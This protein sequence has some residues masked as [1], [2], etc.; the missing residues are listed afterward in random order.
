MCIRDRQKQKSAA[1]AAGESDEAAKL[2]AQI[3]QTQGLL[4]AARSGAASLG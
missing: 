1:E 2:D 4:D 3:T